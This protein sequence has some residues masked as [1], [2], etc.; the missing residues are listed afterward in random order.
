MYLNLIYK[1]H[2]GEGKPTTKPKKVKAKPVKNDIVQ[3]ENN[4]DQS[5]YCTKERYLESYL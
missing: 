2:I 5:F 3:H 1:L 4:K